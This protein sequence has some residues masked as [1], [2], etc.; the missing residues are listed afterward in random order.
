MAFD[1]DKLSPE[2]LEEIK[3]QVK[4]DRDKADAYYGSDMEPDVLTRR[5]SFEAT[6]KYYEKKFPKLSKITDLTSSDVADTIEWAMP[7]LMRIFFGGEEIV[8]LQGVTEEDDEPASTMQEL[9]NYQLQRHNKGFLVFYDW[10][11]SSLIENVG[12][13]KCYWDRQTKVEESYEIYLN[14]Q[15]LNILKQTP[16]T[17]INKIEKKDGDLFRIEYDVTSVLKNQPVIECIPISELRYSPEARDIDVAEFVAHRKQVTAD[18]LRRK[19]NS[20]VYKNVEEAIKQSSTQSYTQYELEMNPALDSIGANVN[21]N[22]FDKARRKVFMYECYTKLDVNEDGLLEDV[23]VTIVEDV[24]IRIEENTMGRHPFFLLSP[25]RDP[26]K[27][28]A[29][30]GM[31]DL[32][33]Q[34]QDLKTA[35]LRQIVYNIAIN[36]DKQAFVNI[37]MLVDVHEFIDGK[38]AVRVQGDPRDAVYY[39]P[40]E[41][42]PPQVFQFLEYIEG[43]KEARTGVTRYNQGMDANSLNKTASGINQIMSASNQRLELIA[44]L[45]S[46]SGVTQLF[47]HLIRLNQQFIDDDV[48]V[49][50]TGKSKTVSPDDLQGEIDIIVNAGM[51]TGG[52]QTTMQNIQMLLGI[53]PQLLE[54]GVSGPEHVSYV[55]GKLV[56]EMGW[57]NKQD[58]SY[59]PE[60]IQQ[61]QQQAQQQQ[62]QQ[63]QMAQQQQQQMAQQQMQ[64][65]QQ[66]TQHDQKM[67]EAQLILQH[68]GQ[69]HQQSMA[70]G[71]LDADKQKVI[72]DFLAK[73]NA[74]GGQ[75]G[76]RQG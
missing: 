9:I 67:R 49:R 43:M 57:K 27:V 58:F 70:E 26:Q 52:K 63:V 36:N 12:V 40:I 30:K 54:A 73:A 5:Q 42:L 47:R 76:Q 14:A 25:I 35:L 7:S 45:F 29:K 4:Y 32:V 71:K 61:K 60:Q 28:W 51:G 23:I 46:E 8:T 38:K 11:K 56:A 15:E 44:R 17:V 10:F 66:N 24:I 72:A 53:Y 21:V 6:S 74:N 3:N 55:V 16:G 62:Q 31:C 34:L 39:A 69:Q 64:Q 48:V 59:T 65:E 37:D 20:G 18:Y 75:D 13:L 19:Q 2:K 50:I 68:D 1:I 41:P 33:S 22:A